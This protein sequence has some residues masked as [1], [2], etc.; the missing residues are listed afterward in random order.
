[1]PNIQTLQSFYRSALSAGLIL[2]LISALAFTLAL[3]AQAVV[4]NHVVISEIQIDSTPGSGGASDDF[5]ELYNPTNSSV[6]LSAWSLQKTTGTGTSPAKVNLAGSIPA[7]G[8]YLVTRSD[9]AQSLL[10]LADDIGSTSFSIAAN[11]VVY[12]V[13]NQDTIENSADADIVD[14]VGLGEAEI[15]EGSDAVANPAEGGSVERMS[16]NPHEADMGNGWDTNDNAADFMQG[17][18]SSPQSTLSA[19]EP[20]ITEDPQNPEEDPEQN[21]EEDPEDQPEQEPDED[22]A[23]NPE[24]E[25]GDEPSD[26]PTDEPSEDPEQDPTDGPEN[27]NDDE[28]NFF[29]KILKRILSKFKYRE[30]PGLPSHPML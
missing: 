11:N 19:T 8:F 16:G 14:L 30:L 2:L 6:D 1:M 17:E 26:E 7:H 25:P 10:D 13:S 3:P 5:V 28:L 21:P 23:E 9:A 4:A 15:F 27:Q 29:E 12:L 20:E 18:V 24:E 22:P